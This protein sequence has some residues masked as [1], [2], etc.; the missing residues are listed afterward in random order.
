MFLK[1]REKLLS[2]AEEDYAK[3]SSALIPGIDNLIGVRIP[4]LRK[5]ANEI[6]KNNFEQ[7]LRYEDLIYFEERM[8]QGIIIGSIKEGKYDIKYILTLVEGFVPKI[9]NWS[10]CDSF[11]AGLKAVKKHKEIVWNFLTPYFSSSKEYE[12]R[13]AVVILLDF[14]IDK[15]YIHKVL[16]ILNNITHQG[17]YVKM[18]VA[19]AISK[20]YVEFPKETLEYL[21]NN[22]LDDFTYNKALQ[23]ICESLKVDRETK[24]IIKNMKR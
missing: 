21:K 3:F 10:I 20:C 2:L 1:I 17:K 23:K 8:L 12:V 16:S 22:T 9:D 19:W 24:K 14:Y 13:F 5:I 11:C 4:L 6:V 15:E 7:Y 18:A